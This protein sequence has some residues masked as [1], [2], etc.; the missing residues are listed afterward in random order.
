M[1]HETSSDIDPAASS[2]RAGRFH[3]AVY[4]A[5]AGLAALFV[6]SSWLFAGNG[7]T[8]YLLAVASGVVVVMAGLPAVLGLTRRTVRRR[9][10]EDAEQG[11][12]GDW[13]A[14]DVQIWTGPVKGLVAAIETMV[15]IAAVA[16]GMLLFGIVLH[17]AR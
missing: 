1:E 5:L 11:G 17:F 9:R 16:F 15:P 8:D 7:R 4:R 3:P 14:H 6:I 10:G 13:A 2:P 12:F